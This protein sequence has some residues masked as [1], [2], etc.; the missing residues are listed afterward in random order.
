MIRNILFD[1]GV[2]LLHLDYEAAIRKA[3][4]LCDPAKHVRSNVFFTLIHR[5][6]IIAEYE[7]DRVT[8]EEFFR[9]FAYL[10]GFRGTLRDFESLWL[11]ILTENTPMVAFARELAKSY[12]VYLATNT[13]RIQV[14]AIEHRFPPPRFFKDVATSFEFGE[15]KPDRAFYEKMLAKFNLSADSCLFVDDRPENV[16]GAEACGIRSVLYTTAPETI[17]AI[18]QALDRR[19]TA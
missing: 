1:V 10:A 2:V 11:D 6:P 16:A 15:V 12:G 18:E 13:G 3:A 19:H 5:D 14:P 7:R 17:R 8:T 4:K 9:H